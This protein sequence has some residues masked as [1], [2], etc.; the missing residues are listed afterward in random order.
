MIKKIRD[1]FMA[2]LEFVYG[3][4]SSQS[5][6]EKA[7]LTQIEKDEIKKRKN[8]PFYGFER[9]SILVDTQ[10]DSC[11]IEIKKYKCNMQEPCLG[12]C[13][14][15]NRTKELLNYKIFPEEF[16]DKD[17]DYFMYIQK[18]IEIFKETRC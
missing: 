12:L 9:R 3:C 13:E 15:R 2:L 4:N 6:I 17:I 18:W 16:K 10:D 11:G 14:K 8:C 1:L 5:D 7:S